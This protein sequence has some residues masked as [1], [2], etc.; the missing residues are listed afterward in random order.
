MSEV[1]AIT[2]AAREIGLAVARRLALN[3][4]AVALGDLDAE[5]AAHPATGSGTTAGERAVPGSGRQR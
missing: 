5:P 1:I 4:H 2:G 3:E